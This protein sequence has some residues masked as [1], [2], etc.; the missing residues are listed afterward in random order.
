MAVEAV[1]SELVSGAISLIDREDTGRF[2][3][4]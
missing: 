4:I 1:C 3:D 2:S